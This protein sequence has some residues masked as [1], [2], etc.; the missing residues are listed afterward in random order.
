MSFIKASKAN[1]NVHRERSQPASRQHLG[2]LEKKKDYKQRAEDFQ[3]KQK[4]LKALKRKAQ[5]KNPDEF[6]FKMVKTRM[7]DGVHQTES[8]LPEY[9][10]DQLKLMQ[11]QDTRYI[12]YKRSA[13]TKK[14]ARLKGT[15][16]ML[17]TED[18][19]RNKHTVFVDSKKQARN[20]D[21]A[22][23]F[24]THP[25]LVDRAYNR[26]TLEA[27]KSDSYQ[28]LADDDTLSVLAVERAKSYKELERRIERERE[29]NIASQKMETKKN[30]MD[31]TAKRRKVT[32][33]TKNAA[34][35]YRWVPCRKR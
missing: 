19:P 22:K 9:S 8:A 32:D 11:S 20:F 21:A 23:H 29:L 17:D 7:Q 28:K 10:E 25:S 26:P 27:L 33:E 5:D 3:R 2:N 24:G 31:K 12:N 13:E 34:A 35:Q 4:T 1:Q 16:H 6:Y 15:L 14:I 18:K 30:L